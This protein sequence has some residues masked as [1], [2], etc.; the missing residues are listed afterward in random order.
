MRA[1]SAAASDAPVLNT[2][3]VLFTDAVNVASAT[4][5][6]PAHTKIASVPPDSSGA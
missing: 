4:A 2:K 3:E 1:F 6:T 5:S